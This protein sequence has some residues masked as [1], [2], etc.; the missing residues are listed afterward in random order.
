VCQVTEVLELAPST[1]SLHLKELKRAGLI[2][3]RKQGRWVLVALSE[4]AEAAP[5]ISTALAAAAGDPRLEAD[6]RKVAELRRLPVEDLCRFG[7]EAAKAKQRGKRRK[8]AAKR[9]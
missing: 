7:F 1:V 4:E 8:A 9:A 5:W 6:R 2:V 3:E